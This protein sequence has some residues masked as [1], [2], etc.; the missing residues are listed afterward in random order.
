MF[1]CV[2]CAGTERAACESVRSNIEKKPE[3]KQKYSKFNQLMF[4]YHTLSLSR[5]CNAETG[6][7]HS[8][9]DLWLRVCLQ[10]ALKAHTHIES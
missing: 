5:S 8:L 6:M 10:F 4:I 1:I 3:Q 9:C 7:Q 2:Q